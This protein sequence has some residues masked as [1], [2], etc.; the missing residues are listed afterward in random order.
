MATLTPAELRTLATA[1]D[2]LG[3]EV[4]SAVLAVESRDDKTVE[5]TWD[6]SLGE[7]VVEVVS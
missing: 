3:I 6:A 1:I 5:V 4:R 2:D 7:H